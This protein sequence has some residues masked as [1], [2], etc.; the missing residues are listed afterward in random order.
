VEKAI[1]YFMSETGRDQS[2]TCPLEIHPLFPP[3]RTHLPQFHHLPT[4]YSK[5]ESINGLNHSLGQRTYYL[6]LFGNI[7]TDTS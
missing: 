6:T 5:F 3:T 4:V 2:K 1:L 7:I